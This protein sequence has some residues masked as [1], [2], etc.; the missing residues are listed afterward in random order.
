MSI[1]SNLI[2]PRNLYLQIFQEAKLYP[3]RWFNYTLY[4]NKK[5]LLLHSYSPIT[6]LEKDR[7]YYCYKM[8][9][10]THPVHL[11]NQKYTYYNYY[12]QQQLFVPSLLIP[13]DVIVISE[14]IPFHYYSKCDMSLANNTFVVLQ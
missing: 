5:T 9:Q 2:L 6:I 12:K 4:N 11:E 3:G 8:F 1:Y 10:D 14:D 13:G 7:K